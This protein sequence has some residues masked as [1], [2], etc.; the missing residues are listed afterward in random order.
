MVNETGNLSIALREGLTDG[1]VKK[2]NP[3]RTATE[4]LGLPYG[5]GESYG[6]MPSGL[7]MEEA[8]DRLHDGRIIGTVASP[9]TWTDTSDVDRD[10]AYPA[11]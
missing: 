7:A 9:H 1:V 2:V 3:D 8:A 11:V 6:S 4:G 10:T 5:L